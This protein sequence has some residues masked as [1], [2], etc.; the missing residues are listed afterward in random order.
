MVVNIPGKLLG[1]VPRDKLLTC[2]QST[3][4]LGGKDPEGLKPPGASEN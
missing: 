3:V 4:T 2:F 1:S